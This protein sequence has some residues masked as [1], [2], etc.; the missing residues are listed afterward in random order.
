MS[1]PT[2]AATSGSWADPP[3]N[4]LF[5]V[6]AFGLLA[7]V[8]AVVGCSRHPE[9]ES[10]LWIALFF[11]APLVLQAIGLWRLR[12]DTTS[13]FWWLNYYATLFC[14]CVYSLL[15]WAYSH[16]SLTG[17]AWSLAALAS[18][19]VVLV[20]VI[21]MTFA[22]MKVSPRKRPD[23]QK[24]GVPPA[25]ATQGQTAAQPQPKATK[26]DVEEP[27]SGGWEDFFRHLSA[28]V[29]AHPFWS[30][31]F[32]MSL[33]LGVSYLFGFA[34]AFHDRHTRAEDS[35]KPA[36][37]MTK[38]ES[39]DDKHAQ[40][41]AAGRGAAGAP[42]NKGGGRTTDDPTPTPGADS[43]RT[44][45]SQEEFRFHFEELKADVEQDKHGCNSCSMEALVKRLTEKV[46][47]GRRVEVS[48]LGHTDSEPVKIVDSSPTRFLSSYLSNYE[49]S[50]ARAQNIQYA[51]LQRLRDNLGDFE[52]I[53]WAI[54]P[55]ADEP[56]VQ[57]NRGVMHLVASGAQLDRYRQNE[58][59][60]VKEINDKLPHAEKRVVIATI[61]LLQERPI[62]I[63][64]DQLRGIAKAQGE[65]LDELQSIKRWQEK[66]AEDS[67]PKELRLMDYMYFSIYTITTTGYGDIVPNTAYAKFV[68]SVANIFEVIF[69]VVFFNA[70]L[71]LKGG[72]GSDLTA[73][74]E[75]K[76]PLPGDGVLSKDREQR[77]TASVTPIA[78]RGD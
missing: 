1:H 44:A 30:I 10:H 17:E 68:T 39:V 61:E 28:G 8:P 34:L 70:I 4:L 43:P 62:L 26:Q 49:L 69:L 75:F 35:E 18:T 48:L 50:Q 24:A 76:K 41:V 53:Q 66:Y 77:Q 19:F 15:W 40:K 23:V 71:S 16:P 67:R 73:E 64:P 22:V 45:G 47:Q 14:Q 21:I 42:E 74:K 60:Y 11:V 36:L 63:G 27:P 33:F 72:S 6:L 58:K 52:N 51:V 20:F 5:A 25:V 55:T 9:R 7:C 32:F 46:E 3:R 65:Q 56:L 12:E 38:R 57:V 54:Y 78:G 2:P 59:A 37:Y 29:G 31:T 13:A